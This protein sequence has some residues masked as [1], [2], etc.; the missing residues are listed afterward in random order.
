MA[1][2]AFYDMVLYFAEHDQLDTG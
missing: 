2:G 1:T